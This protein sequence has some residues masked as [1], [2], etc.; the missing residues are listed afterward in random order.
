M[1]KHNLRLAVLAA[2]VVIASAAHSTAA[3]Q[4]AEAVE[5]T[6]ARLIEQLGHESFA[7]RERAQRELAEIGGEAFDALAIAQEDADVERAMRARFLMRSIR[8]EWTNADDLSTVRAILSGYDTADEAERTMAIDRL[9]RLGLRSLQAICRIVRFDKSERVSKYAALK[10]AALEPKSQAAGAKRDKIV[11]SGIAS[12]PR[13]AADWVRMF[14]K[15]HSDFDA[16]VSAW[17]KRIASEQKYLKQEPTRT[18]PQLVSLL[19]YELIDRLTDRQRWDELKKLAEQ[20]AKITDGDWRLRYALAR[21]EK[22]QGKGEAAQAAALEVFK[23]QP[24]N[25]VAH[26]RAARFLM[27]KG[28]T[29]WS[30]WEF[31]H[32]IEKTPVFSNARISA[33]LQLANMLHDQLRDVAAAKVFE[34]AVDALEQE[35]KKSRGRVPAGAVK[36][37]IDNMSSHMHF[38]LSID[39]SNRGDQAKQIEHLKQAVEASPSDPDVLIAL[40]HLPQGDEKLRKETLGR[41][42]KATADFRLQMRAAPDSAFVYNQFAWLVGNTTAHVNEK[43]AEEAIRAS[44]KSLELHPDT[45]G[46]LDTLAHCYYTKKDYASAVKYQKLAAKYDPHSK[47][48]AQKLELFQ[49][50]LERS[51][52]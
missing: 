13:P 15:S 1:L 9:E 41:I 44:H 10:I 45:G 8:I 24:K 46:Y 48:I 52:D 3:D 42:A 11:L 19:L 32:V 20:F 2:L 26:G 35:V 23:L 6:I 16:T 30:E 39:H 28:M 43:D 37:I 49:K 12:S 31:R 25:A 18:N 5:K 29:D 40:Y 34:E 27:E 36:P 17:T 14:V 22:L 21:V 38:Y 33:Q 7:M 50:A 47:L 4:P 51:K